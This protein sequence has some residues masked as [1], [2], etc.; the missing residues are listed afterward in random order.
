MAAMGEEYKALVGNR[1]ID[2]GCISQSEISAC[3]NFVWVPSTKHGFVEATI[4][5]ETTKDL[6]LE[7]TSARTQTK[8]SKDDVLKMN[9]SKL[10]KL[11]DVAKLLYFNEASV[12]HVLKE[13]YNADMVHVSR[14]IFT[15]PKTSSWYDVFD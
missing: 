11:E 3:K 5:S 12:L 15:S 2:D 10:S 9:P 1:K 8:V 4:T 7:I 13:R 14:P 6:F